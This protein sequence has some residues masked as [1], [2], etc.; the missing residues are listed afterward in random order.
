MGYSQHKVI[1]KSIKLQVQIV[2]SLLSILFLVT[3]VTENENRRKSTYMYLIN[4][5]LKIK[6]H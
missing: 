6:C 3:K 1:I 2:Q 5:I 4:I